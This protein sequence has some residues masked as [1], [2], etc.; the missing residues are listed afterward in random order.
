MLNC[1]SYED[2]Y[3]ESKPIYWVHLDPW[4]DVKCRINDV[5]CHGNTNDYHSCSPYL[6]KTF[7]KCKNRALL[8]LRR[9]QKHYEIFSNNILQKKHY[10]ETVKNGNIRD[11]VIQSWLSAWVVID[12]ISHSLH[13]VVAW[14]AIGDFVYLALRRK[15]LIIDLTDDIIWICSKGFDERRGFIFSP[16]NSTIASGEVNTILFITLRAFQ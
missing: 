4:K 6:N 5:N 13:S 10:P 7:K 2:L 11:C 16:E 14:F 15:G 8:T 9:S 3:I 12:F 1:L